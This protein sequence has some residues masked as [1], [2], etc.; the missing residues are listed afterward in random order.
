MIVIFA[1]D[2]GAAKADIRLLAPPGANY[3]ARSVMSGRP[4]GTVTA[5][6]FARGWTLPLTKGEAVEV[7][8]LLPAGS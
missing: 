8:E 3:Q 1:N 4:L 2:S 5:A 7:I 6:D